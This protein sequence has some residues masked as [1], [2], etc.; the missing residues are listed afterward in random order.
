MD[1]FD[2]SSF[3]YAHIYYA[4]CLNAD[5]NLEAVRGFNASSEAG[6]KQIHKFGLKKWE[7]GSRS[8]TGHVS[9]PRLFV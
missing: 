4:L 1:D 2:Q 5:V 8:I 7:Y 3:P 6:I 9:V